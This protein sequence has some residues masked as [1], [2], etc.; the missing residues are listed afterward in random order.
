VKG[1]E[2]ILIVDD[3]MNVR[4]LLC[5]VVR[6]SGHE[7][8]QA[9]NGLEGVEKCR[10]IEPSVV[11]MD[12][13]M[14]VMDGMEAFSIIHEELP[15]TQ[16]ILLTAFGNVDIAME[17]MKRGAFDY[18][19][20]PANV[21]EVRLAIERAL[22]VRR[23]QQAQ[24]QENGLT[25]EVE[26]EN[27]II[28]CSAVMQ[29]LFK[30]V[31]RV[32]QSNA[33]VLVSGESGSGKEVI[34]KAIHANSLRK[35]LP[36]VRIDCGSIPEGLMESELFGH[37]KG[38]FTGAVTAK[39][40]KIELAN[41][42]TLFIDEVGDLPLALQVKLLRVIQERE[43]ERVGGTDTIRVDVRIIAATHRNLPEWVEQ[44]KFREDLF[45]RLN[46]VPL[47]VPALRERPEDILLLVDY[48][49]KKKARQLGCPVP[50]LTL[51]ARE[52][53]CRYSWPGNVRELAN[54]LERAVVMS[55]GV[56]DVADVSGIQNPLFS[57]G[58]VLPR[59]EEIP[60]PYSGTLR[61]MTHYLEREVI[62][63]TLKK[64]SGNRMRT[65]QALD[66]S[67][68]SLLYKL[69]EHGLTDRETEKE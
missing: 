16:V 53:L 67:R 37:E 13:R 15:E 59:Q 7:A 52:I 48:F 14:P 58:A 57:V 30:T 1:S 34:A 44:G 68:R 18:L 31:G 46:V 11:L 33:T 23:Q 2:R 49:I 9:E 24:L 28:G 6:K 45:Y 25:L 56:I 65:A 12:L 21:P 26:P 43:F 63:R 55:S 62:I 60:V 5:E 61:E 22:T 51:E 4:H 38:A 41:G 40:G 20:K 17:A 10:Q 54:V 42:G 27:R 66:I 39:T 69:E 47:H 36:F 64:F 19:V 3:E 50:L 8:F 32:A 29:N 35:G